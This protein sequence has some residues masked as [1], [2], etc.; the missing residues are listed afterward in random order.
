[1]FLSPLHFGVVSFF[2][3]GSCFEPTIEGYDNALLVIGFGLPDVIAFVEYG[4]SVASD[5]N[6]GG[7]HNAGAPLST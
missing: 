4:A 3:R 7:Q 6:N 5:F 1:L 2:I